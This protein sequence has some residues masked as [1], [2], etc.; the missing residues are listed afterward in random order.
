MG[1]YAKYGNQ[2]IKIGTCERM[3][4]LRYENRRKVQFEPGNVDVNRDPSGL[5]FRLPF[6]D[7]D[8]IQPGG[9]DDYNR[10]LR[11]YRPDPCEWCNG[12]GK[13]QF[14]SDGLCRRCHGA[15]TFGH[16]DFVDA[17]T[18]EDPGTIQLHHQAS[19]LLLNVPCYHGMKL[20]E[21][22]APMRAFWNGKGWSTE[23]CAIKAH[24]EA[25]GSIRVL[26]V[27]H[28]RHCGQMWRYEWEEVWDFIEPAMQKRLAVYREAFSKVA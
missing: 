25:D 24:K 2:S 28:C 14:E 16:S 11:L 3:Y 23:L 6:P 26:P 19:G 22:S 5:F 4:Y 8:H 10:A 17:E 27:V 9:Y 18:M 13:S 7:E 15:G 12:S 20:P 21:V 1:E